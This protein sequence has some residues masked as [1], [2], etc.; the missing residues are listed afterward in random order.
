MSVPALDAALQR[1]DVAVIRLETAV[2]RHLTLSTDERR[3][4]EEELALARR[5]YTELSRVTETV[6]TRLDAAIDRLKLAIGT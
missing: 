1:L 5:E 2:S 4:L 6:S 3:R